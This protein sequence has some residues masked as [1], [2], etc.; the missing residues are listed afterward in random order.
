MPSF[1]LRGST[2]TLALSLALALPLPL[3][4]QETTP[5]AG[6]AE[7]APATQSALLDGAVTL[8]RPAGMSETARNG[9]AQVT[10]LTLTSGDGAP[11]RLVAGVPP[12]DLAAQ[13]RR[14]MASV[15]A[16]DEAEVGGQP[17]WIV[18]GESSRAATGERLEPGS[19]V[20]ARL[21]VPRYCQGDLP[22][23]LVAM[24]TAA[25]HSAV[26][27]QIAAGLTLTRPDGAQDCP[28]AIA[29]VAA[30]IPT[31][32]DLTALPAPSGTVPDGWTAVTRLGLAFAVPADATVTADE[33]QGDR[34]GYNA[35]GNLD[36]AAYEFGMRLLSAAALA[37]MG[38]PGTEGFR[39]QLERWAGLPVTLGDR[40]VTLGGRQMAVYAASG[41]VTEGGE[42]H[43]QTIVYLAATTP[44][45]DGRQLLA[46]GSV[47]R[48]PADRAMD[49]LGAFIASLAEDATAPASA[50]TGQADA[51]AAAETPAGAAPAMPLAL[52]G[53]YVGL[54]LPD[55]ISVA[56]LDRQ[57]RLSDV[58]LAGAEGPLARIVAGVPRQSAEDQVGRLLSRLDGVRDGQIGEVPVWIVEGLAS[59]TIDNGA[60]DGQEVPA[61]LLVP[62]ACIDGEPPYMVG[63]MARPGDAALLDTLAQAVALALPPNAA[64]CP[65]D[66]RA[67]LEQAT[68]QAPVTVQPDPQP[69]PQPQVQPRRPP[70]DQPSA[71]TQAW[72]QAMA[73]GDVA[74]VLAYLQS[75]PRGLNSGYARAWLH[76]RG[77]V[78]PDERAALAPQGRTEPSSDEANWQ[79]AVLEGSTTALWTYLKAEQQGAH[80]QEALAMLARTRIPVPAP[81]PAPA[82][83]PGK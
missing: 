33:A 36:G 32:L 56:S 49:L 64:A 40:Q 29:P 65:D 34:A 24:T 16:I 43:P 23:F 26:L 75:Y 12:R 63:L 19:G 61:R 79:A 44:E 28:D 2:A 74:G 54:A 57:T 51:P 68:V 41:S 78:P 48:V 31:P 8:E 60:P 53:G 35:S 70:Q 18:T 50:E 82:P 72:N 21:I 76:D 73:A 52:L 15:A 9:N 46:G 71:E 47:A 10:D 37:D 5:P 17:V 55:G 62:A 58:V 6:P 42:S 22:P 7:T 20:P 38:G 4:A 39:A 11:A 67:R 1:A 77:I 25:D 66:L 83:G 27:D 45:A 30:M 13:V 3:L 80:R 81:M 59:R 69:D 14:M